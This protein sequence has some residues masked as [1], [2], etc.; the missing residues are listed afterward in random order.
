MKRGFA[1]ATVL[2][3]LT[4]GT[5]YLEKH[6]IEDARLSMQH[7][8]AHVLKCN[9]MQL[10]LDYDRIVEEAR[11]APLRDLTRRRAGGEPLQHLL[12]TVEFRGREFASDRRAL[13]PRPETEEL[14]ERLSKRDWP[15][16]TRILDMGAGSGVLGLTLAAALGERAAEVVLADLSAEALELAR[17]NA[18]RLNL[19]RVRFVQSDLFENLDGRFHLI[20]ANLPYVADSERTELSREVRNDPPEALFGG[21]KGTEILERFLA[22]CPPFLVPGGMVAMEFGMGQGTALRAAAEAAELDSVQ[23]LKDLSGQERF[24]FA[25][26]PF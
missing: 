8:L 9:R 4:K 3:T 24:L 14:A 18:R 7:L 6:G 23:I 22:G 16:G 21:E 25:V 15:E 26:K 17:E 2:D 20:A 11:L 12:G 1:M 19:D 5:A 13:V 10:Y